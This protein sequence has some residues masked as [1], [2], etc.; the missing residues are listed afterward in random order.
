VALGRE[1]KISPEVV[2]VMWLLILK[3]SRQHVADDS[4][5]LSIDTDNRFCQASDASKRDE[6]RARQ[7]ISD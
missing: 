4:T 5:E 3:A 6:S 2:K 7:L 1:A